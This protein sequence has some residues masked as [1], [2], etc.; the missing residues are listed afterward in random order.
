MFCDDSDAMFE[1]YDSEGESDPQTVDTPVR[2]ADDSV[3]LARL[4]LE[5]FRH[6]GKDTSGPICDT[7]IAMIDRVLSHLPPILL[8]ADLL[9]TAGNPIFTRATCSRG[10]SWSWTGAGVGADSCGGV[11]VGDQI[12]DRGYSCH[13]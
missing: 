11:T 1:V 2:E 9:V 5:I 8:F 3:I 4:F 13:S 6:P 7:D 12:I 10:S